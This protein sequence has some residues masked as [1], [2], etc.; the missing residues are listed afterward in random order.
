M[1]YYFLLESKDLFIKI[2][3]NWYFKI[4]FP[5][6]PLVPE[7]W[8]LGR[9]FLRKFPT[10][11]S[12]DLKMIGF[13]ISKNES[14][15]EED[16]EINSN[17]EEHENDNSNKKELNKKNINEKK[18]LFRVLFDYGKIIFLALVFTFLGLFFGYNIYHISKTWAN[19]FI[20]DDFDYTFN[21]RIKTNCKIIV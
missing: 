21:I 4:V 1:N 9:T 3:N 17:K 18:F 14:K 2:N 13:Y 8:I 19:E 15:P 20:D 11:F 16:E 5:V 7:R 6:T 10:V 12:P